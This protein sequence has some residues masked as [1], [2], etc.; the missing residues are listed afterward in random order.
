MRKIA[1][2]RVSRFGFPF[3]I[4]M[5]KRR[6]EAMKSSFCACDRLIDLIDQCKQTNQLA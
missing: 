2:R 6:P 5:T 3:K 4:A 1:P